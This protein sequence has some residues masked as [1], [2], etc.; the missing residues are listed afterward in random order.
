M[1]ES[2]LHCSPTFYRIIKKKSVEEFKADPYLATVLNCIFWVLYGLPFV[3]SDNFLVVTIN[4]IGLVI[5]LVYLC[6]YFAFA[7]QKGRKKMV[8]WL[9]AEIIFVAV[10]TTVILMAWHE[11]KTRKLAFGIICEVF[12][13][14]M[15]ASPL[16]IMKK[17]ITTKSVEYMPFYLSLTNFLNGCIWASY[18]LIK[19]DIFILV[20]NGLG[21][22]SGAV[23]LILY[24]IY[25][26][27]TPKSAAAADLPMK[28][29]TVQLS[30]NDGAL[31]R[32]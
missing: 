20:S 16:T 27:S 5:E 2:I 12:N 3:T 13:I 32:V 10:L 28:T 1:I 25:F 24:A 22:L 31:D 14:I 29:A 17:V 15:Y 11:H 26:K 21:A 23:Q 30:C 8:L 19:L 7:E 18:A 9:I 4:G 6:I